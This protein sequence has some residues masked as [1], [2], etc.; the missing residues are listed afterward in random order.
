MSSLNDMNMKA[1]ITILAALTLA[2][3]SHYSAVRPPASAYV[4]P[5]R[6][7]G[8]TTYPTAKEELERQQLASGT[9]AGVANYFN[10]IEA[11]DQQPQFNAHEYWM[12]A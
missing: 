7:T 3:C 9:L 8:W 1:T 10:A 4:Q 11:A 2:A 5:V 12:Q 6:P